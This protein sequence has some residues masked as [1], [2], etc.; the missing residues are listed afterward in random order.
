MIPFSNYKKPN[1]IIKISG[2]IK[3]PGTYSIVPGQTTLG[4]LINLSGGFTN[5][6]DTTKI[7]LNNNSISKVPDRELERVLLKTELDRSI[8]EKAYIKAR[9]RTQKGSLETSLNNVINDQH[10]IVSNDNIHIPKYFPYVEVI[11]AVNFPGR[12]PYSLEKT[13]SDFIE[14]AGGI[15]KNKSGKRFLV[16][17]TTSQRVKLN[18]RQKLSSGD[19]IFIEE[20]LEYNKWFV[21]KEALTAA[22]QLATIVLVIQRILETN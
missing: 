11:G 4:D 10:I 3:Y 21:A 2:E 20:K 22:G 19:I 14:M 1:D 8:E 12:Y 13:T 15:I 17:S 5:K 6:A 16:K 18:K 7:L 9:I